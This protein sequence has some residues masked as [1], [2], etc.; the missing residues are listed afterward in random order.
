[1]GQIVSIVYTPTDIDPRPADHYARVPL[2][3]ATLEPAFGILT[4][5]KG[6]RP[7]RELNVMAAETL[8]QLRT[9]GYRT[10]PGQMGEQI[11]VSGIE[12]NQLPA[13][14]CLQFGD[15]VI[16]VIKPRTGCE[17]LQQ[18]QGCTPAQVKGRLGVMARVLVGGTIRVGDA[19]AL[20]SSERPASPG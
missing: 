10:A 2:E 4:D 11:V 12:I 13:G 15:I 3:V 17:R 18:I 16:E 7:E 1:M 9:E 14:A 20:V 5:R 8:E 19:V 6:S